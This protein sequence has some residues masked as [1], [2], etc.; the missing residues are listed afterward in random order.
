MAVIVISL[1]TPQSSGKSF[2]YTLG[3]L[4]A[5]AT[6]L[7]VPTASLGAPGRAVN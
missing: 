6:S 4:G 1:G 3:N 5:L 2:G 7:G